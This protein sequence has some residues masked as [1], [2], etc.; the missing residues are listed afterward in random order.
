MPIGNKDW[1]DQMPKMEAAAR[2][3]EIIVNNLPVNKHHI[4][5]H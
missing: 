1:T 4:A 3:F 5:E 2:Y